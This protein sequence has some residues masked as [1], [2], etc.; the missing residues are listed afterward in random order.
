MEKTNGAEI[1]IEKIEAE[2]KK[3]FWKRNKEKFVTL[4]EVLGG[5]VLGFAVGRMTAFRDAKEDVA[6]VFEDLGKDTNV[7]A[8]FEE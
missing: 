6:K 3:S 5:A 4:A 7:E 2:P 8:P 1:K